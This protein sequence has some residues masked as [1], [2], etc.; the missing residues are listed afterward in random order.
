M[1]NSDPSAGN[2]EIEPAQS[3]A[4]VFPSPGIYQSALEFGANHRTMNSKLKSVFEGHRPLLLQTL[5]IPSAWRLSVLAP[6]PDDFDAIGITLRYFQK[7]GNEIDLA[8]ITSAA[9]GVEDGF[10]GAFTAE[11]KA[12]LRE[13]EQRGSCRFF[14]LPEN[15]LKFLRMSEDEQG[16][17]ADLPE[18]LEAMRGYLLERKPEIVFLPHGND[19]N[20][21]HQRTSAFL[22]KILQEEKLFMIAFLNRD[23]KTIALRQDLYAPFDVEESAWKGE[24][25]R[26]HQSQHQRNLNSRGHGF[27]ER[28]LS[29]NRQIA[30]ELNSGAPFAEAFELELLDSP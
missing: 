6:H 11:N 15:R 17:P 26:F 10:G 18:N 30:A 16:H 3:S 28:I 9:S 27:D 24:L 23:P 12:L 13:Y 22:H 25:L 19:T 21:G 7:N 8:V 5:S 29:V 2:E 14:G 20:L 1:G 4:R